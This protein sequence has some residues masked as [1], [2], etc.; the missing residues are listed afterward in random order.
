MLKKLLKY[1]WKYFW[2]VPA[3]INLALGVITLLGITSLI[4]PLW[5]IDSDLIDV[6]LDTSL[7]FYYISIFAGSIA[8]S[9]YIAVRFYR[10]L[11]TDE[12]Y[13]TNTLPVAPRQII[14]S[15]LL[16]SAL[17]SFITSLVILLS[18]ILLITVAGW[19]YGDANFITIFYGIMDIWRELIDVL[20]EYGFH[21]LLF[22]ILL[23]IY[24]IVSVFFNILLIFAAISLGQ[25]FQKHKIMGAILWFFIEYIIIQFGSSMLMGIITFGYLG[26]WEDMNSNEFFAFLNML[27]SGGIVLTLAGSAGLY[28][29]SEYMLK[30]RLN[31]D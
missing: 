18:V 7:L 8:V 21:P 24:M 3:I 19:A 17:W 1:D 9:V 25:L 10:N 5:N 16:V 22:F 29:L 31:L 28:F 20:W 26:H 12:G 27:L 13:L 2:K 14:L 11:Y 23:I 15:K 4:S 6:L 30:K